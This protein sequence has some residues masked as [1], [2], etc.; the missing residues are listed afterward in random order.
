[1]PANQNRRVALSDA[2]YAQLLERKYDASRHG[3]YTSLADILA[4]VLIGRAACLQSDLEWDAAR[5]YEASNDA[6]N[7]AS[8][9][10]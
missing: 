7:D 8:N 5:A 2:A 6:S 10:Q 3:K 9:T 4:D 1:M